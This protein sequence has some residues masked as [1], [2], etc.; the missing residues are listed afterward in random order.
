MRVLI[1]IWI[2]IVLVG[3]TL[4]GCF[5]L[6]TGH[7]VKLLANGQEVP[8]VE[9]QSP[10]VISV[11]CSVTD[12][13]SAE[14]QIAALKSIPMYIWREGDLVLEYELKILWESDRHGLYT[15]KVELRDGQ[16]ILTKDQ[17]IPPKEVIDTAVIKY[18]WSDLYFREDGNSGFFIMRTPYKK[19]AYIIYQDMPI[20]TKN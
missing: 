17:F 8:V 6:P 12:S 5:K 3:G 15:A 18:S 1:A 13:S 19:G 7:S 16:L 4:L 9:W 2:V 10:G 11:P 20:V 14:E